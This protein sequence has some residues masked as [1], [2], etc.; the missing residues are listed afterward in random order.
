MDIIAV[1]TVPLDMDFFLRPVTHVRKHITSL[2][3]LIFAWIL[4]PRIKD[5]LRS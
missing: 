1:N 4:N 5:V 2:R 3:A